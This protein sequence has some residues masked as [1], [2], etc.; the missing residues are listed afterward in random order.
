MKDF[1]N[2]D[3]SKDDIKNDGFSNKPL[4][5]SFYLILPLSVHDYLDYTDF[6]IS[7]RFK[8]VGKGVIAVITAIPV[9]AGMPLVA[10]AEIATTPGKGVIAVIA[11]MSVTAGTPL[12]ATAKIAIT[13]GTRSN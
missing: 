7:I 4:D 3:G 12:V 9:T 11:A 13:P 8:G 1:I 10:T 6:F 2:I 5:K